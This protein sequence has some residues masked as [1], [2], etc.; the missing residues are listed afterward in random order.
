ML[1]ASVGDVPVVVCPELLS[2]AVYCS[3]TTAAP[4]TVTCTVTG[5]QF[6]ACG[7]AVA[8]NELSLIPIEFEIVQPEIWSVT[9]A[10]NVHAFC[11][12]IGPMVVGA[13][14]SIPC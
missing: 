6:G 3:G 14:W 11:P 2:V 10:E 9:T 4:V 5:S 13:T 12:P 7:E 8:V 1:N